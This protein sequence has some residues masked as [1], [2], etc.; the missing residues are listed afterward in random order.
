MN[1]TEIIQHFFKVIFVIFPFPLNEDKSSNLHGPTW[2]KFEDSLKHGIIV[3]L[4]FGLFL[5]VTSVPQLQSK[6][7]YKKHNPDTSTKC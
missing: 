4:L 5:P 7:L 3:L 2:N 1:V 6:P